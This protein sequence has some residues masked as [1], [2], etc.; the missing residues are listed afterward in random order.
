MTKS[1]AVERAIRMELA[2]LYEQDPNQQNKA[3]EQYQEL[4]TESP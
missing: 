1:H 2:H 4:M 3:I